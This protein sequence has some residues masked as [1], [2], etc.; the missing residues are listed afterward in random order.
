[1]SDELHR[2]LGMLSAIL[3]NVLDRLGPPGQTQA[4]EEMLELCRR[5]ETIG[6][7]E[8]RERIAALDLESIRE[9]IKSI[10]LRFHLR[11]QAEKVAILRINRRRQRE[12]TE[13]QP[14]RE[15]VAEAI[16]QLKARGV[17]VGAVRRIL[18]RLDIQPTLT[19]HPTESRRRTLLRKQRAITERLI[20]LDEVG[21]DVAARR[22]VEEEIHQLVM[23]LYVTDEVRSERLGV[24]EEIEGSL[25]FLTES[26]WSAVPRI[27]HDVGL[28][29]EQYF[30]E[31]PLVPP[32]VRYRTWVGG[33]RD[34]NPLVSAGMTR[35]SLR[36][37]RRAALGRYDDK[38]AD[39]MRL[40][41]LSNRRVRTPPALA[42]SVV[43][44]RLTGWVA[45]ESVLRLRHE[46]FRLKIL[47]MRSR[48]VAAEEDPSA[49][50]AAAFLKDLTLLAESL[51]ALNLGEIVRAS[52]LADLM[53]QAR[54][55][56]FHFAALDIRQ[57]SAVHEQVVGDLLSAMQICPDYA[58]LEES[59][60]SGV[61]ASA[62]ERASACGLGPMPTP[63]GLSETSL[64]LLG[65]F[66]V[67]RE[68][69]R[70]DVGALGSYIISMAHG[71]SD[72]LEVLFLMRVAGAPA[73]DIVP[74]FETIDDLTASADLLAA[75]LI[76]PVYRAHVESRGRFQEIM[77]G[78]SD[79][80]KDGGYV[81]S[82]WLLH[83]AQSRLARVCREHGVEFRFFHGRGGTVGR[84]GGRSNRA[85]LATPPDS[86]SG[87]IRMTEQGEVISFRYTLA[88]I[89]HRHLE[90]LTHAMILAES[91]SGPVATA[92]PVASEPLMDRLGRRAM[93]V[94]RELID[95]PAFWT[96][97]VEVS[98]IAQISALPIASRP[99]S[100]ASGAVHFENL[101]AIPW[102]FSWTQMRFNVPGWYGLGSA[103]SEIIAEREEHASTLAKWYQEWEFFRT[104]IDNAQQEMARARL[105]IA[106]CYDAAGGTSL[107]DR[108][109]GEFDRARGAILQI[110]GQ[111]A[112]LDN[113]RV[114]QRS[115][116]ERNGAT[117]VLNLLQVELLRRFREGDESQRATLRPVLFASINGIAAAM[118]STG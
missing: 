58:S 86:R 29:M 68:A 79:S 89:A 77:L 37:H 41:S 36:L 39:L 55:F 99:V 18:D 103:L 108:I 57:H 21:P 4:V 8:A 44:G 85:I 94:Y 109:S 90:Q 80:N 71:V 78:Y 75:M 47:E 16:S 96:W 12:A 112:L 27:L 32:L 26:I 1:M 49:Y 74:L 104:L 100:R 82:S 62:I 13:F 98:P 88:D 81:M 114:I 6:F 34:G 76:D 91:E 7:G 92:R 64:D 10:T 106:R 42:A 72:V 87:R 14:R 83:T 105:P 22:R 11:N 31:R 60:R 53:A 50:S 3:T 35:E 65:V 84:G 101:R 107:F 56:G 17:A 46:P 24:L 33:D 2:D 51:V 19:A 117:D 30:G 116:E 61:L 48:L 111:H 69:A 102:V 45:E 23:L 113:N 9:L 5:G 28:A 43:P 73:M 70:Q 95:D 118:Q 54:I 15:S 97:F 115:I 66:E 20:E 40:L 67:L 63:D 52:G 93:E 38:L 25:Y 110:T 59:E